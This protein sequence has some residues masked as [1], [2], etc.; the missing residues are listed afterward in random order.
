MTVAEQLKKTR[1]MLGLTQA[2]MVDGIITTSFYS[3][4][5]HGKHDMTIDDLL[6]ILNDHQ[7]SLYDFFS[8]FIDLRTDEQVIQ[9]Q[10]F[11][12]FYDQNIPQL[13]RMK[14]KVHSCQLELERELMLAILTGK[15]DDISPT[16]KRE[17]QHKI[18]KVGS[19][20][21]RGLWELLLSLSIFDYEEVKCLMA[22][23]TEKMKQLDLA[24]SRALLAVANLELS[25]V[26]RA[27]REGDQ[28]TAL[29]AIKKINDLPV[30]PIIFS[31]KLLAQYCLAKIRN[32]QAKIRTITKVLKKMG[33]QFILEGM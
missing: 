20:D 4:V 23:V 9:D 1:T 33:Y 6:A 27:L 26:I 14:L 17:M 15:I 30:A 16:S 21:R 5:E 19:W 7:V 8:G 25:F 28:T 24:D 10:L 11:T 22:A 32:D 12:A 2:E 29:A 3:R 31:P 13:K 18:L